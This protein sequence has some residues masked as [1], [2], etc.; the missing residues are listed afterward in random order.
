MI[1]YARYLVD[2]WLSFSRMGLILFNFIQKLLFIKS[3][4]WNKEI[5][6]YKQKSR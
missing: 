6:S 5:S 2:I 4:N 3:K 1:K